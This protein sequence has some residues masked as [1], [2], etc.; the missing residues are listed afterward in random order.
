VD[1]FA[2][3]LLTAEQAAQARAALDGIASPRRN[4]PG[5]AA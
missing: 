3:P 5:G 2:T 4:N 1:V